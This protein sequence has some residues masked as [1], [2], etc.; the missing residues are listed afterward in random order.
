MSTYKTGRWSNEELK[1]V[2]QLV[3]E[4]KNYEQISERVNRPADTI[5]K[6]VEEKLLMN[7]SE[8][9]QI[10]K[11]AENDIKSSAE[12][13]QLEKQLNRD[14]QDVF[15]N[16]WRELVSQFNN[17]VTHTEKLQMMDL[18]RNEILMGR[19]LERINT[20]SET[21]REAQEDYQA[22]R[23]LDLANQNPQKLVDL[24]RKIGD[25]QIAI[26]AFNKEYNEL[27]IRKNATLKDIKGTREQ[28][29]KRLEESKETI[30]GWIAT[31]ISEPDMREKLGKWT[32]KF[33]IAQTVEYQ[34]LGEYHKYD[35][36]Q[37][38]QPILNNETLK[39]DNL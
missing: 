22:E 11:K 6:T 8:E 35:D 19:V 18:I 2:K 16:H 14:E 3:A 7:I 20:A 26:G 29:V 1:L 9:A 33:R 15:L 25:T 38:E 4:G 27:S 24:Q 28:R 37:V 30:T 13:R 32:E 36:G 5:Q 39:D 10:T 34:R 23:E 31:L 17:N 21:I 12:W